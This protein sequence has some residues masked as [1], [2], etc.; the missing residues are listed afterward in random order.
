MAKRSVIL[1]LAAI[2][3]TVAFFAFFMTTK[4]DPLL[5]RIMPFGNDPE[6]SIG[7]FGVIIS[8]ILSIVAT[9]RTGLLVRKRTPSPRQSLFLARTQLAVSLAAL[10]TL[11]ADLIA[12]ARHPSRWLGQPGQAELL[13]LVVGM[14]VVS[15][16]LVWIILRAARRDLQAS[17]H[18]WQ[19]AAILSLAAGAVLALY[20]EALIQST[21]G[22]L[23]SLALG[24]YLLFLPMSAWIIAL[25]P[26]PRAGLPE[27]PKPGWL[28]RGWVQWTA[29]AV[30]GVA[31]GLFLLA[32]EAL[33][34]TGGIAV[35]ARLIVF[36]IFIGV[37]FLG[38]ASAFVLLGKPLGLR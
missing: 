36:S 4:H 29:V 20:P 19:G 1:T 10:I 37:S 30:C 8:G 5:S 28:A 21:L 35:P 13:L 26:L 27:D 16:L 23:L 11:E 32:G 15:T 2:L 7:S 31:L 22:E 12:M 18:P 14:L 34:S 33:G 9:A 25:L 17:S 3:L 38:L 24:I 6:D